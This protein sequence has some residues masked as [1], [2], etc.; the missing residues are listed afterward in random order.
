M[1]NQGAVEHFHAFNFSLAFIFG[2]IN[3]II[4]AVVSVLISGMV[5]PRIINYARFSLSDAYD[6]AKKAAIFQSFFFIGETILIIGIYLV[7]YQRKYD[8]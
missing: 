3:S 5:H 1:L 8:I 2:A 7:I 6:S 4:I